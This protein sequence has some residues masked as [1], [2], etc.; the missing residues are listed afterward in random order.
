MLSVRAGVRFTVA[1]IINKIQS[2][3]LFILVTIATST[4]SMLVLIHRL[5][6]LP[7]HARHAEEPAEVGR[8]ELGGVARGVPLSRAKLAQERA[9]RHPSNDDGRGRGVR[10]RVRR[11]CRR[12]RGRRRGGRGGDVGANGFV[13]ARRRVRPRGRRVA[14]R[15]ARGGRV[16]RRSARERARESGRESRGRRRGRRERAR[17]RRGR[18]GRH[19]SRDRS[20]ERERE[21]GRRAS[22]R[23]RVERVERVERVVFSRSRVAR[24]RERGRATTCEVGLGATRRDVS[25]DPLEQRPPSLFVHTK[26]RHHGS[27][28]RARAPLTRRRR[29]ACERSTARGTPSVGS[30]ARS[31]SRTRPRASLS[32]ASVARNARRASDLKK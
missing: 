29:R 27:K 28:P 19:L 31:S 11:Q 18:R 2:I 20:T 25:R 10:A 23:H 13:R 6:T 14:A 17:G 26:S 8:R 15:R 4:L 16:R 1:A 32:R 30:R 22:R 24:E 7:L 3:Q 12:R 9:R 21:R 5:L